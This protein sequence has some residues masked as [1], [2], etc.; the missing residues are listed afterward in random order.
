MLCLNGQLWGQAERYLLRSL[1]RRSDAQTHALLGSLYDRLDR[2]ADAVR[3]WRL[4][5][6]ASMASSNWPDRP[7]KGWPCRSSCSPGASPTTSQRV[8]VAP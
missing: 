5:T 6:A 1:S 4:A 8:G 2:P 7:T 3:H